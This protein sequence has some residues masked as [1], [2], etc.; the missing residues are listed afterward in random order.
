MPP[1]TL[2]EA[3][4]RLTERA[5]PDDDS[6]M[7]DAVVGIDTP[8]DPNAAPEAPLPPAVP[9]LNEE[10]CRGLLDIDGGMQLTDDD[11]IC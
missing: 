1:V 3:G 6:A 10:L 7:W 9:A 11:L 8:V 2:S 4:F 5:D